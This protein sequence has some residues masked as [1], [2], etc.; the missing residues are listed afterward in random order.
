MMYYF[1]HWF[2][3]ISWILFWGYWMITS[4][5]VKKNKFIEPRGIRFTYAT[6]MWLAFAMLFFHDRSSLSFL[7]DQLWPQNQLTFFTGAAIML[8]GLAFAIWA[9]IHIGQ[10]WSG[11]VALKENHQLIRSGP[12]KLVRHPIYTGIL[13]GVA[14]TAIALAEV[15]GIVAFAAFCIICIWKSRR[16]ESLMVQTFGD[17]Y[18]QYRK[19]VPGLVPFFKFS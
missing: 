1:Y 18:I 17:Q 13:S 11:Y 6:I 12:Y 7:N 8:T 10:N 3:P 2:F 15:N 14:G 9:R 19:E 4:G 5:R 16:E